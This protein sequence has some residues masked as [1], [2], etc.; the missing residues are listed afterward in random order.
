MKKIYLTKY[1]QSAFGNLGSYSIESLQPWDRNGMKS[2][3]V[4]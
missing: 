4:M 3:F 2:T 1:T